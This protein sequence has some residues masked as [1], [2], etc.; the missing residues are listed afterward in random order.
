MKIG[1]ALLEEV[2]K[3]GQPWQE[4]KFKGSMMVVVAADEKAVKEMLAEDPYAV[5][6]V[7]DVEK[8]QITV[9]INA[10]PDKAEST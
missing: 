1:G 3:E 2:P 6:D 4:W 7:W 9:F 5:N 8:A 10:T